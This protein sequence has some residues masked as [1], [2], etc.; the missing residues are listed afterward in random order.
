MDPQKKQSQEERRMFLLQIKD[1]V[2]K[3]MLLLYQCSRI[4]RTNILGRSAKNSG[5]KLSKTTDSM[6]KQA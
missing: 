5:K 6:L 3:T 2:Q 4:T 1:C